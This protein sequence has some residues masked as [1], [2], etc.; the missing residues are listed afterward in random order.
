MP[1]KTEDE[2]IQRTL[3]IELPPAALG[4]GLEEADWTN[5]DGLNGWQVLLGKYP[6][7]EGTIDLSGYTR[8]HKTFYPEG[9]IIQEGPYYAEIGCDGTIFYTVVS[10]IPIDLENLVYQ[11][12][13]MNAGLGFL[14]LAFTAALI[15]VPQQNWETVM[16]AQ[17]EMLVTN[18]N[19]SPNSVGICEPLTVKQSGSM[20][21][22]ATETLYVAKVVVGVNNFVSSTTCIIPASRIIIP[23]YIGTEPD[24][25]YMMRLKRSTELAN[26]V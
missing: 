12:S 11:C 2:N 26:Q 10:T 20:A 4:K 3:R 24:V 15:D 23:G 9:A 14:N 19:I 5:L 1:K 22:T 8:D 18:S 6:V 25:E 17:S 16:F 13:T 21:P 7:W